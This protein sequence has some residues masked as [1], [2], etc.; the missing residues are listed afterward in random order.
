MVIDPYGDNVFVYGNDTRDPIKANN[1]A[2]YGFEKDVDEVFNALAQ[3]QLW[4]RMISIMEFSYR[5]LI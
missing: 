1:G 4:I 3:E 5:F 2:Y